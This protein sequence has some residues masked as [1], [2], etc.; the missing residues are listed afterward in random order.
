MKQLLLLPKTNGPSPRAAKIEEATV[1]STAGIGFHQAVVRPRRPSRFAGLIGQSRCGLSPQVL[2]FNFPILGYI[3]HFQLASAPS[4]SMAHCEKPYEIMKTH[5]LLSALVISSLLSFGVNTWALDGDGGDG[6]G[7][8][9]DQGENCQGGQIDGSETLIATVTLVATN[10]APT[11]AGGFAKLISDNEDGVVTSSFSLS[12]TGLTSGTYDLS[13]VKKSDGSSVDL[14]QFDVGSQ[15]GDGDNNDGENGD[16]DGEKCFQSGVSLDDVPLPSDLD[17]MDI[18]Q[19]LISDSDGNV[20]LV[21]DLVTPAATS[22][23]KFRANLRVR[24]ASGV[25][26]KNSKALALTNARKGKRA[27]R[28]TMIAS[29]VT[30]NTTYTVSVNGHNAGTVN[31]NAKGKVLVRTLPANL[32]VVKSVHLIDANGTTAVR[33]K[34]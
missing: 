16:Q 23:I 15:E 13:V 32:L 3:P 12:I 4:E 2:I 17:P 8:N 20:V 18:A 10:N 34:F 11:N 9:N 26:S 31:S 33:A 22:S 25:A 7:D 6:Q 30:P 27:D 1:F 14:G 24:S 19:I 21:G 28:F 29:G 5:S